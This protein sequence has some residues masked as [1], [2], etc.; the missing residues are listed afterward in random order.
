M[1]E[2]PNLLVIHCD[3]MR[4]MALGCAGNPNLQTPNL[5]RLAREGVRCTR[6]YTPD[7]VCSPARS[8]MLTGFLPHNT[9]VTRNNLHLREDRPTLAEETRAAGYATGH[10][11]KWHV[12]GGYGG[13]RPGE[14]AAVPRAGQRGFAYWAGYE[15]GHE[16]WQGRYFTAD[17]AEHAYP[18][19]TW[20]P[21]GQTDLALDFINAHAGEPW[22]LDL[23]WGPPH[24]PLTQARP[25]DLARHPAAAVRLRANVPE[26]QA[27]EAREKLACYYAMI[28]GLDRNV[29]RLLD[30]LEA[31]G[32]AGTTLVLFTS[33]HGDMMLSHGCN[34]KRRPYE[35][36]IR[37]PLLLRWPGV[38]P[39]GR[40]DAALVSLVD[41]V[42]TLRSLLGLPPRPADGVD[43]APRLRGE[44]D[45]PRPSSV[46]LSCHWLGCREHDA[47]PRV[48]RPWRGVR[49]ERYTACYLLGEAGELRCVE[50]YDNDADPWQLVNRAG[51]A[52]AAAGRAETDAE[53]RRWMEATGDAAVEGRP[54]LPAGATP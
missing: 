4:G 7:P 22:H 54:L 10:I 27:A 25:A 34:W 17:G 30:G 26:T 29:G 23:G 47:A 43:H 51:T 2:R 39:A 35:E 48:R 20:E 8:S 12:H 41:L 53:L 16:Y 36:S 52:A 19:G 15:H 13:P 14:Y 45:A 37:V 3:E 50:L 11:G 46:Y 38:L 42:P 40:E 18:D 33:D 31:A 32:L 9:G 28:E 5:D 44:A 49:T 1:P 21:D 6:A 24:F